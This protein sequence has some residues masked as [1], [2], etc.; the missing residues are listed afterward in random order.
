MSPDETLRNSDQTKQKEEPSQDRK[1][2]VKKDIN[3]TRDKVNITAID[4]LETVIQLKKDLIE[5]LETNKVNIENNHDPYTQSAIK[6]F[7]K[8]S[9]THPEITQ[10]PEV[11]KA[12]K[13]RILI[14][15]AY[16]WHK[17]WGDELD[18]YG[19][20]LPENEVH[21]WKYTNI[22]TI[23]LIVETFFSQHP[24]ILK[25]PEILK[26]AKNAFD[27]S[28]LSISRFNIAEKI[29]QMFADSHEIFQEP[30]V[31]TAVKKVLIELL[32]PNRFHANI[33]E[34]LKNYTILYQDIF[35]DVLHSPDVVIQAVKNC[36]PES[37]K[38]N[39]E[40]QR[41]KKRYHGS[42]LYS[43]PERDPKLE[44]ITNTISYLDSI[45]HLEVTNAFKQI[46]IEQLDKGNIDIF[47][48]GKTFYSAEY[49]EALQDNK[50]IKAL[51]Q[52]TIEQLKEG[53]VNMF[54]EIKKTFHKE[55]PE[56]FKDKAIM[57]S[58][59]QYII[60]QLS[61]NKI[62]II[63]KFPD[64]NLWKDESLNAIQCGIINAAKEHD[65]SIIE[66]NIS[67]LSNMRQDILVKMEKEIISSAIS[68]EDLIEN[69]MSSP[70]KYKE[71]LRKQIENKYPAIF[72]FEELLTNPQV[73]KA[74]KKS[75]LLAIS[76][77]KPKSA[78][79]IRNQFLPEYNLNT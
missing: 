51:T 54:L 24:D 44:N 26:A 25:D 71:W 36:I 12:A 79:R 52:A 23:N 66:K 38:H 35:S 34:K 72:K 48:K 68:Q 17:E 73:I 5:T 56:I 75:F 41:E 74:A 31:I 43:E 78:E 15:L 61:H 69:V 62:D 2:E 22:D 64:F 57:E 3:I 9:I 20:Y 47:L 10:D 59:D 16:L 39:I 49:S 29:Y 40:Y 55:Y 1:S 63:N 65:Y 58:L 4:A 30:D 11:L 50:V 7:E 45:S 67:K 46:I 27:A 77:G 19:F 13:K 28:T 14:N 33:I 60:D 42:P 53:N 21:I 76:Q 8:L 37:I 6:I 70:E 18:D 32:K